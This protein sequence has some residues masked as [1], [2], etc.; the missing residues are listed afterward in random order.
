MFLSEP[1]LDVWGFSARLS[2]IVSADSATKDLVRAHFCS[3]ILIGL[4]TGLQLFNDNIK[5]IKLKG[6]AVCK[7]LPNLF[8]FVTP[9][10]CVAPGKKFLLSKVLVDRILID[11]YS[12]QNRKMFVY[13]Q[14]ILYSPLIV[15]IIRDYESVVPDQVGYFLYEAQPGDNFIAFL[16]TSFN[17]TKSGVE[18]PGGGVGLLV[19]EG[20]MVEAVLL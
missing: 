20:E 3:F 5:T 6:N 1:G 4:G 19:G 10:Q 17:E 12:L 7:A 18:L 11:Y 13:T 8:M 16:L 2:D 9:Y 14:E 15:N